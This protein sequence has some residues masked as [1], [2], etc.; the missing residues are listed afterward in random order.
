MEKWDMDTRER[1]LDALLQ[2]YRTAIPDPEASPAFMPGLWERIDARR[3]FS[4]RIARAFVTAAAALSLLLGAF[5]ASPS[6][7]NSLVYSATYLDIL[8][9]SHSPEAMAYADV[10]PEMGGELINQ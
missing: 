1:Q 4:L 7:R 9:D 8:D 10:H 6:L 2:A 3:K 5:L